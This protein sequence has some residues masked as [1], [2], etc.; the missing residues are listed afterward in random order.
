[1]AHYLQYNLSLNPLKY[2]YFILLLSAFLLF[3]NFSYAALSMFCS[4]SMDDTSCT[5]SDTQDECSDNGTVTI[6]KQDC[7]DNELL[8]VNNKSVLNKQLAKNFTA[9]VVVINKISPEN[10]KIYS[11]FIYWENIPSPDIILISSALLI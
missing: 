1:M 10:F 4:M 8:L 11:S 6:T 9:D 7:C 2:K 3:S 5:C